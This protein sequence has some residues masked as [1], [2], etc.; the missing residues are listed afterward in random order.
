MDT[1]YID[2][3]KACQELLDNTDTEISLRLWTTTNAQGLF[4]KKNLT[5]K[6]HLYIN[7]QSPF[8]WPDPDND[9]YEPRGFCMGLRTHIAVLCDGTVVP[10]CLDGNSNISLGNIFNTPMEDILNSQRAV[11]FYNGFNSHM[12]VEEL[13]RH[14]SF[15]ERFDKNWKR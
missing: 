4:G 12:A 8:Q 13:C 9:Y 7:V 2:V 5:V 14:C 15:K 6:P 1:Y 11:D 3:F 10:C